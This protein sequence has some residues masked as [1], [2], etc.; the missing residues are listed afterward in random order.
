MEIKEENFSYS[1]L[2]EWIKDYSHQDKVKC[3]IHS[4]EL[5]ID[6][7]ERKN[8]SKAAR[9]AIEAA[10]DW[11][12]SPTEDNRKAAYA[13][14]SYASDAHEAS[15][16]V[17]D[18][19]SRSVRAAHAA[20]FAAAFNDDSA[21]S[22][23]AEAAV[24]AACAGG[25]NIKSKIISWLSK[26]DKKEVQEYKYS[27]QITCAGEVVFDGTLTDEQ[28]NYDDVWIN[29]AVG[30]RRVLQSRYD[31]PLGI[32]LVSKYKEW[33]E[34]PAEYNRPAA[35]AASTI[36]DDASSAVSARY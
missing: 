24:A 12:A 19:A 25:D 17:G 21:N 7:Y 14:Y 28:A 35:C 36:Y 10:K 1:N 11:V 9:L 5:V 18:N 20:A 32:Q 2:I 26:N 6:I 33:V 8:D 23:S 34:S 30:S 22:A 16:I 27:Y 13:A 4:A 29:I 3:A 31:K 15:P